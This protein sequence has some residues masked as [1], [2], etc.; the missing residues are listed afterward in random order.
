MSAGAR[1]IEHAM[2]GNETPALEGEQQLLATLRDLWTIPHPVS[3]GFEG[4]RPTPPRP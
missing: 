1:T 3:P 4:P 2:G